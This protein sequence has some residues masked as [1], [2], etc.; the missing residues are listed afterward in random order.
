MRISDIQG[1]GNYNTPAVVYI[2]EKIPHN[3][4]L[5]LFTESK[6]ETSKSQT[7]ARPYDPKVIRAFMLRQRMEDRKVREAKATKKRTAEQKKRE[8]LAQLEQ[9]QRTMRAAVSQEIGRRVIV[10]SV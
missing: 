10:G 6:V 4:S 8:A 2:G 7:A 1:L 5:L 9:K 3:N